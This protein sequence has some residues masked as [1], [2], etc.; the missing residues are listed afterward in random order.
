MQL[1]RYNLTSIRCHDF[2]SKTKAHQ[3][4]QMHGPILT[5]QKQEKEKI[6]PEAEEAV[7]FQDWIWTTCKNLV[8]NL[9]LPN[10][11]DVG[12]VLLYFCLT[13]KIFTVTFLQRAVYL[14]I[15][16][17]ICRKLISN[18]YIILYLNDFL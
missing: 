14:L 17:I 3:I 9:L 2:Y 12:E 5:T 13:N 4:R 16:I 10:W 6:S 18:Y 7:N 1:C 15:K 8:N 11:R